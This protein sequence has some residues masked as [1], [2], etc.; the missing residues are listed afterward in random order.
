MIVETNNH[1]RALIVK[2]IITFV[3]VN[4]HVVIMPLN[5]SNVLCMH[6]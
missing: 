2:Q 4:T 1:I 6:L 3:V 5:E